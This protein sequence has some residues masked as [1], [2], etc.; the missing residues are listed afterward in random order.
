MLKG[1]LRSSNRKIKNVSGF[2]IRN[3]KKK[4]KKILKARRSIKRYVLT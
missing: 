2:L 3:S 1:S 4:G